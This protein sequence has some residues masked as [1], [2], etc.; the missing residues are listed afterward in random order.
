MDDYRLVVR[1]VELGSF[2]AA[3]KSLSLT[4]PTVSRR[5]E[6]LEKELGAT[7]FIRKGRQLQLTAAGQLFYEKARHIARL[8]TRSRREIREHSGKRRQ[9]ISIAAHESFGIY[10]LPTLL[11]RFHEKHPEV[12]FELAL[13]PELEL[14]FDSDYDFYLQDGKLRDSAMRARRIGRVDVNVYGSPAFMQRHGIEPASLDAWADLPCC[15]LGS[16][17]AVPLK[18]RLMP[19]VKLSDYQH[20]I[21]TNDLNTLIHCAEQGLGTIFLANYIAKP[22]VDAGALLKLNRQRAVYSTTLYLLFH[23]RKALSPLAEE[24]KLFFI[25]G[26]RE[27]LEA[28]ETGPAPTEGI[29]RA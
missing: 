4:Q 13:Q 2:T 26:F 12:R 1:I 20:S 8:I 18:E 27:I 19:G 7:L 28:P 15:I 16:Y 6:A 17:Y 29:K 24:F 22:S 21:Y 10:A 14:S 25:Q 5:V 3:A 11:Q 9:T 23:S